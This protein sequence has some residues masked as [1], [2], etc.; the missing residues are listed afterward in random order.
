MLG[1]SLGMNALR[2][3]SLMQ[4][5]EVWPEYCGLSGGWCL[6]II[7]QKTMPINNIKLSGRVSV[8]LSQS[9]KADYISA[10]SQ[11]KMLINNKELSG[12]VSVVLYQ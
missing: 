1:R 10:I 2:L 4:A 7:N 12:R 6:D 3:G 8:V 9:K 11:Q 5:H